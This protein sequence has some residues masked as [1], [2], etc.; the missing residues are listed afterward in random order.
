MGRRTSGHGIA[1]FGNGAVGRALQDSFVPH[2]KIVSRGEY[3]GG[4]AHA[5]V[6]WPAHALTI[7]T[8][9]LSLHPELADAE[10][11]TTFCNGVWV[12]LAIAS[13]GIAYVRANRHTHGPA[14]WRVPNKEVGR[15]MRDLGAA[16]TVSRPANHIDYLWGKALFLLPLAL[17]CED[18]K[19]TAKQAYGRPEWQTYFDAVQAAA[20]NA[21][22]K[23][24][25]PQVERALWLCERSPKNWVPSPSEDEIRFFRKR[26]AVK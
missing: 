9:L 11:V 15:I 2:V 12:P 19:I 8:K 3:A 23:I 17:A 16:V 1:I 5:L 7:K 13:Q 24:P 18:K 26:L 14:K 4:V 22:C 6:C 21:G 20:R 25:Q 10:T